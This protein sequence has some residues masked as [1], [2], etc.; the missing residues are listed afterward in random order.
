MKLVFGLFIGIFAFQS[1]AQQS[2]ES[3]TIG[4]QTWMTKN[5]DVSTFR[6][7][8]TIPHAQTED[9]WLKA[10]ENKQPAWCYFKND[11]RNGENY[12]KLYNW[13]AVNDSRG[14]APEGWHI[15]NRDEYVELFKDFLTRDSMIFINLRWNKFSDEHKSYCKK[16][17]GGGRDPQGNFWSKGVYKRFVNWWVKTEGS[18]STLHIWSQFTIFRNYFG[19][20]ATHAP[21]ENGFYVRC[22][23]D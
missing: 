1:Y 13:Y 20:L 16:M 2:F 23:K 19:G 5:L 14:L 22:L 8:D 18:E 10:G 7:G 4:E 12:G 11:P 9:E 17:A 6:N 21:E 3:V 15:P